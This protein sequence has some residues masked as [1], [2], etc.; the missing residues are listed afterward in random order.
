MPPRS[1]KGRQDPANSTGG[2]VRSAMIRRNESGLTTLEWLLIVAAV[3]GLAA[4]AVVLVT[5]VVNDTS[6]QISGSS[7]RET[8]AKTAAAEVTDAAHD[9][10]DV[11]RQAGRDAATNGDKAPDATK[12]AARLIATYQH[13]C[14]KLQV[15]YSDVPNLKITW[16]LPTVTI[17]G[18][19][20]TQVEASITAQ[21]QNKLDEV[22]S[23]G[24]VVTR[25]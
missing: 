13:E 18:S 3:A 6:Q 8:A 23:E 15:I 7:A 17:T 25:S 19:N 24:C 11:I 10:H 14:E 22:D 5:N 2:C 21:W 12:A 16:L 20:A 4:L 1:R 9:E